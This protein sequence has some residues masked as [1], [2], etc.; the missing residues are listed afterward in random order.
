MSDVDYQYKFREVARLQHKEIER[1]NTELDQLR[2]ENSA[3][4]IGSWAMSRM[5]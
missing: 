3:W 1:L 2:A 5:L 4:S